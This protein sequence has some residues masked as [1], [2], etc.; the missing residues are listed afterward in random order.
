MT[1]VLFRRRK[2]EQA[3]IFRF[4]RC[5]IISITMSFMDRIKKA[6]KGVVDAGAKTMLKVRCQIRLFGC[7]SPTYSLDGRHVLGPRD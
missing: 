1:H 4:S 2:K 6:S 7:V 5:T 3:L